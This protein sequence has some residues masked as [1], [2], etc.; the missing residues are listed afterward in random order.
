LVLVED[1]V[2]SWDEGLERTTALE[3]LIDAD[4]VAVWDK[5]EENV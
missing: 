3:A 1:K 2:E 5:A 4:K